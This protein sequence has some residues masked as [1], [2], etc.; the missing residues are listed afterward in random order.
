[1]LADLERI[2]LGPA[3]VPDTASGQLEW[4]GQDNH[5]LTQ[6]GNAPGGNG[7][8]DLHLRASA[9]A[10]K[11]LKQIVV[12]CKFPKQLRAWRL[13]TS[14]SPHW[15]V[16]ITRSELSPQADLY[17]EP[18]ADDCFGM[19]FDVAFTYDDGTTSKSTVV[20]STHTSD[21]TKTDRGPQ[22]DQAAAPQAGST[23]AS[24]PAEILLHDQGRL[25]AEI[26]AL[27][28]QSMV[29]RP[30]WK[31]EVEVPILQ[32]KG[33]WFANQAAAGVRAEFDKQLAAP[34]A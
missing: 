27:N 11:A 23:A 13:D 34:V 6:V 4:V 32:V 31:A 2:E 10:P 3:A 33:V 12:I 9:L 22:K 5:D 8:Q 1:D 15:R 16:G 21:Q 17:L 30:G 20:A 26:I 24:G 28:P 29:L 7:I 19:K 25:Q 14:L 18:P